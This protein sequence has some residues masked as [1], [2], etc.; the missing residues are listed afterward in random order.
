MA[1]R[2]TDL[3][4]HTMFIADSIWERLCALAVVQGTTVA[5]II[6]RAVLELLE[7]MEK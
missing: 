3:N 1:R 2:K 6:R 4:K 5:S 7:R